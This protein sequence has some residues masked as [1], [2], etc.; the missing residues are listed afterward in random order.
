MSN[1]SLLQYKQLLLCICLYL[2][3]PRTRS[4]ISYERIEYYLT[5]CMEQSPSWDP[6]SHSAS[7]EIPRFLWNPEVQ[8]HVQKGLPM[9][10]ILSQ[11]HP[12]ITSH[13]VSLRPILILSSSL[14]LGLPFR[15]LNQS[16]IWIPHLSQG[17]DDN[18][19]PCSKGVYARD[20]LQCVAYC[21]VV[22][23]CSSEES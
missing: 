9:V 10:P 15:F 12:S 2:L 6:N 20:E 11:M 21:P 18:T 17:A 7:Q 13:P 23:V 3:M 4:V 16:I 5:N 1:Y 8:Y 14:L 22:S 19:G